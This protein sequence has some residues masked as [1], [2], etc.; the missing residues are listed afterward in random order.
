L[1]RSVCSSIVQIEPKRR[2][3]AVRLF[4]EALGLCQSR[5]AQVPRSSL[6]RDGGETAMSTRLVSSV[7]FHRR[8]QPSGHL[9]S[10]SA[11]GMNKRGVVAGREHFLKSRPMGWTVIKV[12]SCE[13]WVRL[14]VSSSDSA[15]R[16]GSAW[17]GCDSRSCRVEVALISSSRSPLGKGKNLTAR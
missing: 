16:L 8:L 4:A 3:R 13:A 1:I 9:A 6:L 14:I 7:S 5:R 11:D 2:S 12:W 17:S 10:V 15:S